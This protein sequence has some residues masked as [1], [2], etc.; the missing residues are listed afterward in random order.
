MKRHWIS[1]TDEHTA[2]RFRNGC[3][4]KVRYPSKKNADGKVRS[5]GEVGLN[6]YKC[7]SCHSWH[8]GHRSRVVAI[9]IVEED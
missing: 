9:V 2:R 7:P 5:I 1:V 8:I 3:I 6:S 4:G